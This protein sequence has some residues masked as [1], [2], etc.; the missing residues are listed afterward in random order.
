MSLLNV[1]LEKDDLISLVRSV[2]S[3]P[4]HVL[5]RVMEHCLVLSQLSV[6]FCD[7]WSRVQRMSCWL[8]PFGDLTDSLYPAHSSTVATAPHRR[9]NTSHAA[10]E[11]PVAKVSVVH[12]ID[13]RASFVI[14]TK[15]SVWYLYT[16]TLT[17]IVPSQ[18]YLTI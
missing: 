14:I 13:F 15:R 2:T 5:G 16:T 11:P 18:T 3:T 8:V 7:V 1:F 4:L 10:E 17:T 6:S 12:W 9:S